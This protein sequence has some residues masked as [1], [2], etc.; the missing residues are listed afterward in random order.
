MHL[1]N[2][3]EKSGV[4]HVLHGVLVS[5]YTQQAVPVAVAVRSRPRPVRGLSGAKEYKPSR[6][7]CTGPAC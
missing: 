7:R 2:G 3:G 6:R 5:K 1:P 4:R